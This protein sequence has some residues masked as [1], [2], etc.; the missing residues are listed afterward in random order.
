MTPLY[1]FLNS[2]KLRL[3]VNLRHFILTIIGK[4]SHEGTFSTRMP[5]VPALQALQTI[6]SK[7]KI[8]H[9]AGSG[10]GPGSDQPLTTPTFKV[11]TL[12]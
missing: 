2:P 9:I 7:G 11:N 10:S 8:A 3:S 1:R 6:G 5:G 4:P 12:T